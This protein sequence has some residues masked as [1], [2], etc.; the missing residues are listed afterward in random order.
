[1]KMILSDRRLKTEIKPLKGVKDVLK[2]LSGKSFT[3]KGRTEVKKG[4]IS[5]EVKK[6]DEDLSS[7]Y[8]GYYTVD[9]IGIIAYLI[10]GWKLH[11]KEIADLK[12]KLKT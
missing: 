10:E 2:K 1:M 11:E 8:N 9:E 4:F 7:K 6:I 5:Q 3:W 12:R